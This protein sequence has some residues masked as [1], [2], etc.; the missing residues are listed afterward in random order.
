MII[1]SA[2]LY[3]TPFFCHFVN[4]II[5]ERP[6]TEDI[7]ILFLKNLNKKDNLLKLSDE[8]QVLI[9][10]FKLDL[11]SDLV[12][13]ML[14]SKGIDYLRINIEDIPNEIKI[15]IKPEEESVIIA[16]EDQVVNLSKIKIVFMRYF[17]DICFE[18][19]AAFVN[20]F[21]QEQWQ[22]TFE[23]I[24][25][26]T[27]KARWISNFDTV[28]RL[29]H[30]KARQ[31][32]LAKSIGMFEIPDTLITNDPKLAKTFY[33]NHSENIIAK[34]LHNHNVKIKSKIYMMHTKRLLNNDLSKIDESL[35]LAPCIFQ[36]KIEK[37]SEL[38]ITVVGDQIFAAKL[39]LK[40]N[41]ALEEDIHICN[42]GDD[43]D[44]EN[45]LGL[46]HDIKNRILALVAAFGLEYCSLD[47]IVDKNDKLI[48]L[49][50]NP[51]ASW[52][53]IEDATGMPITEAV[54]NLI[55]KEKV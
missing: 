3:P 42:L 49:E 17:N 27:S 15:S 13:L 23:I 41:R 36:E 43:I 45:F 44:I 10:S 20:K 18:G 31:L 11:E 26:A 54:T 37:K 14:L 53:Y 25:E 47:F 9:L 40:S 38:R 19:D 7:R 4:N 24:K 52:T 29:Q 16:K 1:N 46:T 50:V 33:Y 6:I 30:N 12:S 35:K 2:P 28:K 8:S 32:A 22:S 55:I 34:V 51:T 48:F 39:N 5:E 21:M